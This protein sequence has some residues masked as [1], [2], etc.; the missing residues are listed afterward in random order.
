SKRDWSSDVCSSDLIKT[1]K[2]Y[3]KLESVDVLY[4]AIKGKPIHS[5]VD[6]LKTVASTFYVTDFDFPKA[7]TKE[8]IYDE[9]RFEQKETIDD[10]SEERRVGKESRKR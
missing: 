8:T 6:Q 2:D 10:R 5:M 7:C 9:I 3:Y 4:A 1:L